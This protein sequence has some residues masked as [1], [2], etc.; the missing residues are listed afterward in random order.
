MAVHGPQCLSDFEVIQRFALDPWQQPLY[1][2]IASAR[3]SLG[4]LNET[5]CAH[6]W[7][8]TSVSVRNGLVGT[9][10]VV[11]VNQLYIATSNHT[12]GSDDVLNAHYAQLGAVLEA[13]L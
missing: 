9:G 8:F 13:S 2:L 6:L 10:L 7:L 4:D 12:V 11:R 3:S 5:S 1:E